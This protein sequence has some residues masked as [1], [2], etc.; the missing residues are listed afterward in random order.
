[1]S[2][3][4]GTDLTQREE[5]FGTLYGT[6][7]AL[8]VKERY[9]GLTCLQFQDGLLGLERGIGAE[10]LGRYLDGLLVARRVGTQGMLYPVAQLTQDNVRDVGGQLR[11]E[12]D[13]HAL[14]ADQADDLLDL[15]S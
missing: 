2:L 7:G 3:G 15:V 4:D 5:H 1:M 11:D 9:Q 8:L 6:R 10:G 12:E 13:A 14:A